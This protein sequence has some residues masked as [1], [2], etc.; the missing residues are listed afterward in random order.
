[1]SGS[2]KIAAFL[3]VAFLVSLAAGCF[4]GAVEGV[5]VAEVARGEVSKAVSAVGVLDAAQ[6]VDVSPAVSGTIAAL[7]VKEGDYVGAGD[8]LAT[9]DKEELEQQAAQARAS[10]LTSASI[11]DILEGQYANLSSLYAGAQYMGQV[12]QSM[13]SQI[14]AVVLAFMDTVSSLASS[15][16]KEQRDYLES[17]LSQKRAEYL[18]SAAARPAP[19]QV[20]FSGYPDSASAAD[21]A[22]MEAAGREYERAARAAKNPQI[23]APVA[24]Y[25]VF[26]PRQTLLASDTISQLLGG[27]GSLTSSMGS[28]SAILGGDLSSLTGGAAQGGELKVG[29]KVTAG[30]AAFQ[31]VDLENMKVNA[32]VEETD[33]PFIQPGQSVK[34]FL[35]AYPDLTFTGKVFQV[36]VKAETGSGGTTVFPVVVQ[37]DRTDIPLRIG[38]NATVDITVLSKTDVL[39]IPVTALLTEGDLHY[40]YVVEE[41]KARRREIAI[42]YKTSEWVEVIEGLGEGEKIVVEGISK[43]KNGQKVE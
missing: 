34:I 6:P 19:P 41:G 7:N 27:L 40:V 37:M 17:L 39:S 8:V 38:Y 36:G 22:R 4:G 10:Y 14:D 12:L 28:L 21:A 25:V 24:G 20:T 33:I 5:R 35:D 16:P 9:L 15:L 2:S 29:S 43:V 11:G 31:I 42:G 13:Q 3:T 23:I 18:A 26:P 32:Q 30:Q 1:M